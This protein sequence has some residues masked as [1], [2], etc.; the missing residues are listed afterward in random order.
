VAAA[1]AAA[2]KVAVVTTDDADAASQPKLVAKSAKAELQNVDD[3]L[4]CT[5]GMTNAAAAAALVADDDDDDANDK[6]VDAGAVVR[7]VVGV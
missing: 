4:L 2:A 3:R 6:V 1:A 7:T 5:M